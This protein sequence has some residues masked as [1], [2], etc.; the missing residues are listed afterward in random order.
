MRVI[1]YQSDMRAFAPDAQLAAVTHHW[2]G[3]YTKVAQSV[4]ERSVLLGE[5]ELIDI[6]NAAEQ[7]FWD[8]Y[9]IPDVGP[10]ID[11][12]DANGPARPSFPWA[13]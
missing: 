10:P 12:S 1:A 2:G 7:Y 4:L 8:T 9:V 13:C 6:I 5:N 3:F 11:G